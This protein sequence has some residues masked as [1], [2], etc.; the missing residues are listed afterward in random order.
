MNPLEPDPKEVFEM[1]VGILYDR[2]DVCCN[3]KPEEVHSFLFVQ[4][5]LTNEQLARNQ[6]DIREGRPPRYSF[7]TWHNAVRSKKDELIEMNPGCPRPLPPADLP[8]EV[9]KVKQ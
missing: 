8:V 6:E 2:A 3:L 4:S 9:K 5:W 1:L 7:K